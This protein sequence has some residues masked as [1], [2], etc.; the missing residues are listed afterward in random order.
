MA[1]AER[2][3]WERSCWAYRHV[4]YPVVLRHYDP[5]GVRDAGRPVAVPGRGAVVLGASVGS[6][7]SAVLMGGER[8][9][10][11]AP[12]VLFQG[13]TKL[14]G[15]AV[16]LPLVIIEDADRLAAAD[17]GV[18]AVAAIR[19]E[20]LALIYLACQFAALT[21]YASCASDPP[22]ASIA[23]PLETES[24]AGRSSS[25]RRRW[26]MPTSL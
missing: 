26:E 21:G 13:L 19:G 1:L 20:Q 8:T 25:T 18:Q 9:R 14:M 24:L 7:V 16:I 2:P 10:Q 11:P 6:G 17:A 15:V 4:V 12:V 23:P 5:R 22:T 3:A